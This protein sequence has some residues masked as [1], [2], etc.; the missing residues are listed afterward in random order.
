MHEEVIGHACCHVRFVN[1]K[2]SLIF[3]CLLLK[4]QMCHLLITGILVLSSATCIS[5]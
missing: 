5:R 1:H 3:R 2:A 4:N